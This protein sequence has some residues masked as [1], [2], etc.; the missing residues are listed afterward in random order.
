[1]MTQQHNFT[2]CHGALTRV[3]AVLPGWLDCSGHLPEATLSGDAPE[4]SRPAIR[5]LRQG[6]GLM[7]ANLA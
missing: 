4:A 6:R 1:M 7:Q 2:S 5:S 3:G